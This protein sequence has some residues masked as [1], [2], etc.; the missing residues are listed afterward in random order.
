MTHRVGF[1]ADKDAA[2]IFRPVLGYVPDMAGNRE[3]L[4]ATHAP[5]NLPGQDRFGNSSYARMLSDGRQVWNQCRGD[6]IG[7]G[8]VKTDP[9]IR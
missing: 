5:A 9:R 2:H 7:N 6:R 1:I 3:P 8:G 4:S